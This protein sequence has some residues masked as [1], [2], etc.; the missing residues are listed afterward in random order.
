[1]QADPRLGLQSVLVPVNKGACYIMTL[2]G[3]ELGSTDH[4][5]VPTDL[6]RLP[7]LRHRV[8]RL[9]AQ[10]SENTFRSQ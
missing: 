10:A 4:V 6:P 2:N 3:N 8:G 1:M 5:F 9:Q 7:P